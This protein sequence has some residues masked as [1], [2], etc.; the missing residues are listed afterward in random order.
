MTS[1]FS[2]SYSLTNNYFYITRRQSIATTT[3]NQAGRWDGTTSSF[4]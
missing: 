4:Q 3:I 1:T 2:S